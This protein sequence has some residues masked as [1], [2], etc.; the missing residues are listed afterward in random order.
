MIDA[1][2]ALESNRIALCVM[3]EGDAQMKRKDV[4]DDNI[5]NICA[6]CGQAFNSDSSRSDIDALIARRLKALVPAQSEFS[7]Q[8][9]STRL[10]DEERFWAA[11]NGK[12][13]TYPRPKIVISV[14][15]R[16][17]SHAMRQAFFTFR[18]PNVP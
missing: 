4:D 10:E 6:F 8:Q 2:Y 15:Q 18:L 11:R 17:L 3:Q 16:L 7:L 1:A 9:T 14:G 12:R 5:H 13:R